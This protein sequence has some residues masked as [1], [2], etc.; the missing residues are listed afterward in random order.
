MARNGVVLERVATAWPTRED[1]FRFGDGRLRIQSTFA[2]IYFRV[3]PD[4][5]LAIGRQVKIQFQ[6]KIPKEL[7]LPNF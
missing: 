4:N 2:V 1:R 5:N 6:G 3:M 7:S